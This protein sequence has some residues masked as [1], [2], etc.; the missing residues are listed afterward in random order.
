MARKRKRVESTSEKY[1]EII[2]TGVLSG[3]QDFEPL[4]SKF[5]ALSRPNWKLSLCM[6]NS[7]SSLELVY[8]ERDALQQE[9]DGQA[10]KVVIYSQPAVLQLFT[11]N[12]NITN[13]TNCPEVLTAANM[14]RE[15][16][17]IEKKHICPGI[18]C[19]LDSKY[20]PL[21]NDSHVYDFDGHVIGN[22]EV[23]YGFKYQ[24]RRE[25]TTIR[26]PSCF[27][28]TDHD[29]KRSRCRHC[30]AL[31][32]LLKRIETNKE[33]ITTRN[34]QELFVELQQLKRM[35]INLED[36]V[37]KKI[38]T[39]CNNKQLQH[40]GILYDYLNNIS[41]ILLQSHT[42]PKQWSNTIKMFAV[43]LY[44]IGKTAAYKTVTGNNLFKF[45]HNN[46][47]IFD[48]LFPLPSID[49]VWREKRKF[50]VLPGIHK[51]ILCD[52]VK[53]FK[54]LNITRVELKADEMYLTQG[55]CL[56]T[57]GK[58][59]GYTQYGP[60]ELVEESLSLSDSEFDGIQN[61]ISHIVNSTEVDNP[62]NNDINNVSTENTRLQKLQQVLQRENLSGTQARMILQF[63]IVGL[64]NSAEKAKFPLGYMEVN[65]LTGERIAA[66]LELIIVKLK[67]A[68]IECNHSLMPTLFSFD[69]AS[70]F[71]GFVN[72]H[73]EIKQ[74]TFTVTMGDSS[75][76]RTLPV[77]FYKICWLNGES[78]ELLM[79]F[80]YVHILKR[81]RNRMYESRSS[82]DTVLMYH[83]CPI[84]WDFVVDLFMDESMRGSLRTTSL[85]RECVFLDSK[86]VMRWPFA[87][88][89]F[90]E[91]VV[92]GLQFK[93]CSKE[94]DSTI[95][96]LNHMITFRKILSSKHPITHLQ[97]HRLYR[98]LQ[99]FIEIIEW[100]T[101]KEN[102]HSINREI[103]ND[104]QITIG[105]FLTIVTEM[106]QLGIYI[107][108]RRLGTDQVESHFSGI[109]IG[110][111]PRQA[112]TA[113]EHRTRYSLLIRT[114]LSYNDVHNI[115]SLPSLLQAPL[116]DKP[117]LPQFDVNNL[118]SNRVKLS[119]AE[120]EVIGHISGYLLCKGLE[121]AERLQHKDKQLYYQSLRE[122]AP[123]VL[124]KS[125]NDFCQFVQQFV[126]YIKQK[127]DSA[128]VKYKADTLDA[129]YHYVITCPYVLQSWHTFVHNKWSTS[130]NDALWGIYEDIS[131]RLLKLLIKDHLRLKQYSPRIGDSNF[132]N[133]VLVAQ[134]QFEEGRIPAIR[135]V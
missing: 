121:K 128:L 111:G 127:I 63:Y 15:L 125:T 85:T 62:M 45:D 70:H 25:C 82:S 33:R 89:V 98:L 11:R 113:M 65:S 67:K 22:V 114:T 123:S 35:K 7:Q 133:N 38:V 86:S 130:V 84:L 87:V 51:S 34:P 108:P 78:L 57:S 54:V 92:R 19:P 46:R 29:P 68:C 97:D 39:L 101:G 52:L 102:K 9:Y 120:K 36:P 55:L 132:R 4:I 12:I 131:Y 28:V 107:I 20:L 115:S 109:R 135:D 50:I 6:Q 64:G 27:I 119:E 112:V 96:Y 116:M 74:S 14:Q 32:M 41:D 47:V 93:Y 91:D 37:A 10:R 43:H 24:Q 44:C 88:K 48:G 94:A 106:V 110:S 104:L 31:C 40:C 42:K 16:E 49:T 23:Q 79:N 5:L 8:Y 90:D 95:W 71:R 30:E 17:R 66:I 72:K 73:C 117:T 99:V 134:S 18:I 76:T 69:G 26:H 83:S 53:R 118:K 3:F 21:I 122:N 61:I 56:D 126:I 103:M 1:T 80:D 75:I 81:F 105:S 60:I 58:I 124:V 59:V 77:R 100:H 13:A 2:R 129:L